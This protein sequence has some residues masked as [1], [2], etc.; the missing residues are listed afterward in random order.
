MPP[1]NNKSKHL[2]HARDNDLICKH[3]HTES[4]WTKERRRDAWAS[5]PDIIKEKSDILMNKKGQV[6][7]LEDHKNSL[8]VIYRKLEIALTQCTADGYLYGTGLTEHTLFR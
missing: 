6:W 1:P 3:N 2:E 8:L 4:K 7:T 5:M